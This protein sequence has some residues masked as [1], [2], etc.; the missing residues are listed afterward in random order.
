MADVPVAEVVAKDP[1]AEVNEVLDFY[2][3]ALRPDCTWNGTAVF[4]VKASETNP[5]FLVSVRVDPKSSE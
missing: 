5:A 2:K 1:R 3:F 4:D